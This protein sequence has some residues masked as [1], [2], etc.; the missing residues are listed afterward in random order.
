MTENRGYN[1]K[2]RKYILEF[3]QNNCNTT[4]AVVDIIDYL[5]KNGFSVNFTTIYRFLNKLVAERKV[6][7]ISNESGQRAVYQFVGH[8]NSCNEH[9]HIQCTECGKLEHIECDFME[10]IKKHLYEGHGFTI[11]C[12][13]SILYGI[14]STC[15][16]KI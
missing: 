3:L 13:G 1:T 14:C 8:K 7:K 11:K 4:V 16:N 5:N 10:H 12:D 2:A 15:K 9:I 6:I